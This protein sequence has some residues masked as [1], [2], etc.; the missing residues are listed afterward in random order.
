MSCNKYGDLENPY[1]AEFLAKAYP[2]M[3]LSE[4]IGRVTNV[5]KLVPEFCTEVDR[6]RDGRRFD[7][8][9]NPPNGWCKKNFAQ[10]VRFQLR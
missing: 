9:A 1:P 4:I 6:I 10:E 2:N 7:R 8:D 3:G 5:R